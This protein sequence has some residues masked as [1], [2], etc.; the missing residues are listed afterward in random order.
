[1]VREIKMESLLNITACCIKCSEFKEAQAA[2]TEALKLD[3]HNDLALWRRSKA[4]SMPIN[5]GVPE[6]RLAIKDLTN[7]ND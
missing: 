4:L 5:A 3:P 2:A 7:I 6:F 1:V